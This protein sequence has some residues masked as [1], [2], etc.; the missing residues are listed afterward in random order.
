[1]CIIHTC[2]FL[3]TLIVSSIQFSI[4]SEMLLFLAFARFNISEHKIF[5]ANT[6]SIE[7]ENRK[8]KTFEEDSTKINTQCYENFSHIYYSNRKIEYACCIFRTSTF[9]F[10]QHQSFVLFLEY[11]KH[12][13]VEVG[14]I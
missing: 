7:L 2:I 3:S 11:R 8:K 9:F 5:K 13:T 10:H 6:F 14:A 4:Y 1:M 12:F